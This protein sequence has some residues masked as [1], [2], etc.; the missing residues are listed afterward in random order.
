MKDDGV[1]IHT[2]SAFL[3]GL[4]LMTQAGIP[5]KFS[6]WENLWQTWHGCLTDHPISAVQASLAFPLSFPEIDRVVI[7]ADSV[8][9][10]SQIMS[11]TN[12]P[13]NVH[14][15]N[16]QCDDLNLVNPANWSSL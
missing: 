3:Q 14:L 5:Q 15:P 10:L 12:L 8:C 4:L 9:Q 1:E 2:R 16:L 6:P 7:G 13:L 11:V